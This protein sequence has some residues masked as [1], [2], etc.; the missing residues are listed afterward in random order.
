[1]LLRREILSTRIYLRNIDGPRLM[2]PSGIMTKRRAEST[3]HFNRVYIDC[4]QYYQYHRHGFTAISRDSI[5][6][7][8]FLDVLMQPSTTCGT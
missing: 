8:F 2:G 3:R 4:R 1:M 7:V 6:P 5:A